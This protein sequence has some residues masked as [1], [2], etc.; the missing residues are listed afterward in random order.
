MKYCG[1]SYHTEKSV[2]CTSKLWKILHFILSIDHRIRISII[3]RIDLFFLFVKIIKR[4]LKSQNPAAVF[5]KS[6]QPMFYSVAFSATY[7]RIMCAH[8]PLARG[9]ESRFNLVPSTTVTLPS[10]ADPFKWL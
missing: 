8:S 5:I 4:L 7:I 1:C 9:I 10:V 3:N 2:H 6:I